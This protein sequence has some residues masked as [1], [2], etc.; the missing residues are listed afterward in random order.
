MLN[1]VF[2]KA[3]KC[4]ERLPREI[5]A[6]RVSA[7]YHRHWNMTLGGFATVLTTLVSTSV[8]TG[9]VKAATS[10]KPFSAEPVYAVVLILSVFAPIIV[11]LNTFMHHAEDSA[12]HRASVAGYAGVLNELTIFLAKYG[13]SSPPPEKTDEALKDYNDIMNKYV[14]VLQNSITLTSSAYKAG[15]R[16]LAE[17]MALR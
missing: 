15:D 13:D 9:L 4:Q 10:T 3:V 11:A 7:E 6:H 1:E 12:T 5:M 17:E 14:S 2:T 16:L 8:F